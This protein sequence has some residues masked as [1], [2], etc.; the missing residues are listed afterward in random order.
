MVMGRSCANAVLKRVLS[1]S[2]GCQA[3]VATHATA[4]ATAAA[5]KPVPAAGAADLVDN[6][7]TNH[8]VETS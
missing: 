7:V 8:T 4:L 3:A 1:G 2:T 5:A 6:N